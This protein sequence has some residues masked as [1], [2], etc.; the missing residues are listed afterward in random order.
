MLF[1]NQHETTVRPTAKTE[2]S[3]TG[4]HIYTKKRQTGGGGKPTASTN[5]LAG[6]IYSAN[7]EMRHGLRWYS[8]VKKR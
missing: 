6:L 5:K 7:D 1:Y 3:H 2:T 4:V 8:R